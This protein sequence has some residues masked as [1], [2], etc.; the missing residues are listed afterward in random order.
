MEVF[1]GLLLVLVIAIVMGGSNVE[2]FS[3]SDC[4]QKGFSKEFCVTTPVG[5][6]GTGTCLCEDGQMGL[7]L[8]GFGGECVCGPALY[9]PVY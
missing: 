6:A 8:P 5:A 9:R 3:Y 4:R 2:G 1:L 7:Q